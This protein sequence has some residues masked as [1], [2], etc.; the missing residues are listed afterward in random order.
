MDLRTVRKHCIAEF[1][2]GNAVILKGP[3]GF[4]KTDLSMILFEEMC[5]LHAGKRCGLL[6]TFIATK[7]SVDAGGLPWKGERTF[8]GKTYTVTDP[9]A[10]EWYISVAS[11]DGTVGLPAECY[12]ICMLVLEEWGQGEAETKRAFA[13]ILRAGGTPPY[14]MPAGSWRLA[15]SNVDK[16]DGVTK[17][18]DFIIGR[19]AEYEVTG[20][21]NVWI[22]DFA[23]K[24]YN[25]QGK[26]WQTMPVTKVFAKQHPTTLFEPKPKVQGPWCNPRSLCMWDRYTQCIMADNNGEIPF[27]D[28]D[29]MI[30]S[31]GK[32]GMPAMSQ[33]VQFLQFRLELPQYE[34][35][36]ADPQG[37]DIPKK[38]D[39]LLLMAY[40]LAGRV[41]VPDLGPVIDYISRTEFPK[42]MRIT[43]MQA[44]LR[45][46]YK[47]MVNTPPVQNFIGKHASL[48]AIVSSLAQ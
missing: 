16:T 39:L 9:A 21:V 6:T 33:L 31:A 29:Y 5:K 11:N 1:N 7:Q 19:R 25:W 46:D 17:E 15:L 35:I 27:N 4:G 3:P 34:D 32:I 45:R 37:T 36:C 22:E 44:L 28:G 14:Y 42:D 43:F 48:V 47:N 12:D 30:G 13:E 20:D 10:P 26:T 18:F 8:N 41:V 38:A 23:D 2:A 40:E 24:P